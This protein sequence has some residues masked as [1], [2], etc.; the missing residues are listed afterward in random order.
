MFVFDQERMVVR[1]FTLFMDL[2]R[3]VILLWLIF[4]HSACCFHAI[5]RKAALA[6][7][8]KCY[9]FFEIDLSKITRRDYFENMVNIED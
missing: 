4:K 3:K 2:I 9:G 6:V 7:R 5:P 1:K 8:F